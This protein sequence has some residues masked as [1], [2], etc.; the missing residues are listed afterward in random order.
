VTL[1]LFQCGRILSAAL[2]ELKE[3]P[4]SLF[5]TSE[6]QVGCLLGALGTFSGQVVG[7]AAHLELELWNATLV[8]VTYN[9]DTLVLPCSDKTGLC[10]LDN[11]E[12]LLSA[13]LVSEAQWFVDCEP[14]APW[15][16]SRWHPL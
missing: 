10:S 2:K 9:G 1:S 7:F 6:P 12:S 11:F 13:V 4:C 14:A 5:T 8:R 15:A 16:F 3:R